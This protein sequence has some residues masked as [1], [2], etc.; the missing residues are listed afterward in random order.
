MQTPRVQAPLLAGNSE[1]PDAA[2]R[3][4]VAQGEEVGGAPEEAEGVET[5]NES[6]AEVVQVEAGEKAPEAAAED[7]GAAVAAAVAVAVCRGVAAPR[8]AEAHTHPRRHA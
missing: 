3:Q 4:A 7:E 1:P 5:E 2:G 8:V 6:V